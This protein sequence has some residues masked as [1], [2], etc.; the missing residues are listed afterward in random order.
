MCGS[1][2]TVWWRYANRGPDGRP[3]FGF[4]ETGIPDALSQVWRRRPRSVVILSR[5]FRPMPSR[6]GCRPSMKTP[7][8]VPCAFAH[9]QATGWPGCRK[10]WW[11]PILTAGHSGS[12]PVLPLGRLT[13]EIRLYRNTA[14]SNRLTRAIWSFLE[15]RQSVALAVQRAE[16]AVAHRAEICRT[17]A[18]N[19]R[20]RDTT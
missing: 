20:E 7:W 2:R 13:L 4:G 3:M 17:P 1:A 14:H 12:G 8:P 16:P 15:V 6:R 5:C 10:A 9:R 18:S 19:D 11:R